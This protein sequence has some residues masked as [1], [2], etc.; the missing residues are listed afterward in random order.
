MRVLLRG[1]TSNTAVQGVQ[2]YV[3]VDTTEFSI[4]DQDAGTAGTQPFG[5]ETSYF[6]GS[7]VAQV[8]EVTTTVDSLFKLNLDK[9]NLISPEDPT[10]ALIAYVDLVAKDFSGTATVNWNLDSVN[11]PNRIPV[12]FN[13]SGVLNSSF[14]NPLVTFISVSRGTITGTVPLEGDDRTS[15]SKVTTFWL[16]IPGSW[17][18]ISDTDYLTANDIAIDTSIVDGTQV[19]TSPDSSEAV[20]V[21]TGSDG[22][23]TLTQVPAGTYELVA[24]PASY[25]AGFTTITVV[26]GQALT[27]VLPTALS[28]SND[29]SQLLGGDLN[30]DNKID[31]D[32]ESAMNL[33]YA[34]TTT[35]ANFSSVADIDDDGSVLLSDLLILAANRQT[36]VLSGIDPVYKP[37]PGVNEGSMLTLDGLPTQMGAGDEVEVDLTLRRVDEVKGYTLDLV[38][39]PSTLEI[40]TVDATLLQSL[41]AIRVN[42]AQKPGRFV[43]AE[44]TRGRQAVVAEEGPLARLRL[45]ALTDVNNPSIAVERAFLADRSNRTIQLVAQTSRLLPDQFGLAQ[46]SPNPFN[47]STNITFDI[48][49]DSAPVVLSVY[50]LMGQRVR[51]LMRAEMMPAGRYTITWDGLDQRGQR[52]GSGVYFYTLAAGPYLESRKMILMK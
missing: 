5:W 46:N 41:S 24:K 18:S 3:N 2:L 51:E 20:Q 19:I 34:A 28:D 15:D 4:V 25:L 48:P 30:D 43:L 22:S 39:D 40:V 37:I 52:A 49:Q 29:P 47:P 26:D 45:R 50:N 16:R 13:S 7:E 32:D 31:A 35:D 44:V 42:R 33:A 9:R 14:T 21:L 38:Y 36:P 27:A 23:F 6:F 1:S 8:N 12:F 17:V 11:D 10:D